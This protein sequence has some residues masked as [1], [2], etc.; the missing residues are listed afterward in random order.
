MLACLNVENGDNIEMLHHKNDGAYGPQTLRIL[1]R[2]YQI[3]LYELRS[4]SRAKRVASP[5]QEV[6][7]RSIMDQAK[8]GERNP[9]KLA[10]MSLRGFGNRK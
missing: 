3:A 8:S 4:S 5:V 6:V 1:K 10:M 9:L 7:A 2:S